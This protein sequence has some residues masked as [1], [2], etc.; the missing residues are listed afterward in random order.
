[1]DLLES[2][3]ILRHIAAVPPGGARVL[4]ILPEV[5]GPVA[6]Q[7]D[8]LSQDLSGLSDGVEKLAHMLIH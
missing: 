5:S 6:D 3:D 8:I 1:M 4:E 7:G 2:L